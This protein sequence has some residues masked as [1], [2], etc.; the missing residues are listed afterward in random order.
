MAEAGCK[1]KQPFA[2]AMKDGQPNAPAGYGRSERI[3]TQEKS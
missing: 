2:I 1:D 3:G